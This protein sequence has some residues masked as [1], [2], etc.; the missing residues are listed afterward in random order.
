ML[1]VF[2]VV[3][4][5][6]LLLQWQ[7]PAQA[8]G[9]LDSYYLALDS[10]P[11]FQGAIQEHEAGKQFRALGRAALLPRLVYS[12]NRGR[13]WSDV[14]QSTTRGDI[15]E[16]RDYDSYVSTFSLQQPLF[17]YEA[18]SRYRK[19]LSQA[20]LADE[21]FRSQ[22]QQLLLR[23][24]EAY[25]GALLAKEQIDLARS[26]KRSYNEQFKLNQRQ[27]ERGNGT[28]TDTLETQARFNL[29]Q[30][31]EIEAQDNQDSALRELERLVGVPLEIGDL[32]PLTEH[33][34]VNPLV[35]SHYEAWRDL[36]MAENP[37]LASMRHAVDV[38]Q[39]EV[40]QNRAGFLP[41]LGL[42][43]SSGKSKSGSENTYNQRYDT[44]SVGIQLSIP[45]FSG[46]ETLA[47]TRQAS[48][49][50]QQSSYELDDKVAETL[51]QV[52]KMFNLSSSS[53]AKIKAYELGVESA[54]TLVMATR[55]SIAAGVRVNLDLLNAE[56]QLFNASNELSKAKYDY[57]NAWTRL[58]FFA[59]VLSERD[60][61]LVGQNFAA[62]D[63]KLSA[64]PEQ[65][66]KLR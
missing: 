17:D 59:G 58:R 30:A 20:L 3:L 1:R 54:Q 27:F 7:Q 65:S 55:K 10:D 63:T 40:E 13:S 57:L 33:F 23:V 29:A 35:P 34:T 53:A 4:I 64:L 15:S 21:R 11:Q 9:L 42:Y 2:S 60:L 50:M 62:A 39:Y 45:L 46:G 44:D 47:A 52:R 25:S 6:T 26:Q 56:Q 36:A 8:L 49:R 28:K 66:K 43:A 12:Y 61:E 5:S 37:E 51:N 31:Q 41:R 14:T 48:H 19:G 38:A 24:L 22:S 16:Q 32:E 18:Y